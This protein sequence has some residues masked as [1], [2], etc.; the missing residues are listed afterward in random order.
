MEY[1]SFYNIFFSFF[2]FHAY[3]NFSNSRLYQKTAF[4]PFVD[5]KCYLIGTLKRLFCSFPNFFKCKE[6]LP[7][8]WIKIVKCAMNEIFIISS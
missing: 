7:K 3:E 1:T 8:N 2:S 4:K 5:K 6:K